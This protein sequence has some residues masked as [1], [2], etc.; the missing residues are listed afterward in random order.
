MKVIQA[1]LACTALLIG[2]AVAADP[3]T[4]G[5]TVAAS[6]VTVI[7]STGLAGGATV[8]VIAA[9]LTP[10][11]AVRVIECD[12]FIGDPSNDCSDQAT[13]TADSAGNVSVDVTLLDP[14]YRAEP[15]GDPT[16]V[17]CRADICRIFLV[18]NDD[19]GIQQELASDNLEFTG[20]PA[21][22]A[23]SPATNLR[24]RQW[25]HV[26][27]TARE[28]EGHKVRIIEEAC[29]SIVQGSGCYGALPAVSTTVRQDGTYSVRYR[30][31][32]FLANGTDC[33]G[34]ILGFC[35]LNVVVLDTSGNPDD[36][37]G[38]SRRGQ[39]GA[40]LAFRTR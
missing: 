13:T 11:A 36:S 5:P 20:S 15:F 9:G 35:E 4:A 2:S 39:P 8:G 14:V 38:V 37:F 6:S 17:Y 40:A 24:K 32:R 26:T 25:V 29:F 3:A 7:P 31:R 18:W 1:F 30:V 16:P 10:S 21:T 22:I 19:S 27:G 28:A 12:V 33:T 23:A 34:D